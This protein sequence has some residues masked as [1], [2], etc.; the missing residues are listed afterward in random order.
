MEGLILSIPPL[1]LDI[2][3]L[4][5]I[6]YDGDFDAAWLFQQHTKHDAWWKSNFVIYVKFSSEIA[7][8]NFH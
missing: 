8:D 1:I 4:T 5:S 6:A 7:E 3:A 2:G